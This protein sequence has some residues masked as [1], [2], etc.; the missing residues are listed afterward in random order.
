M[1]MH[2]W[3]QQLKLL[4]KRC[5]TDLRMRQGCLLHPKLKSVHLC[6]PYTIMCKTKPL[7]IYSHRVT[8]QAL[9]AVAIGL[10]SII[11]VHEKSGR[12]H[13]SK[14]RALPSDSG[15]STTS[16]SCQPGL[17]TGVSSATF[18]KSPVASKEWWGS[19]EPSASRIFRR[20]FWLVFLHS[21]Y[22]WQWYRKETSV[23][24]T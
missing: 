3:H 9:S 22:S 4:S 7:K 8:E 14:C 19:S 17:H 13:L 10:R 1:G 20:T 18:F 5:Q 15:L 12:L 24:S 11:A 2:P 21:E 23:Q 16:E 6:L